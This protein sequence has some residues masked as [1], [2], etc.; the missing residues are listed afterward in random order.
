MPDA[1][2]VNTKDP[3]GTVAAQP[4][5]CSLDGARS[6]QIIRLSLVVH[7]LVEGCDA[8]EDCLIGLFTL[9]QISDL[10]VRISGVR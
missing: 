4:C 5:W 3:S 8:V 2:L 10:V 6:N 1:I 9:E 7:I